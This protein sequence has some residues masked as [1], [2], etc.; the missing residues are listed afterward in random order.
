[1]VILNVLVQNVSSSPATVDDAATW[2]EGN[3]LS[4]YVLADEEE[5]WVSVWG[6][7]GGTSQHSYTVLNRDGTVSWR[8]DQHSSDVLD[9]MT[10]ALAEA[11]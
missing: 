3:D 6:G 9:V 11:D 5:A 2:R 7:A 8:L 4:F 10:N 1:M